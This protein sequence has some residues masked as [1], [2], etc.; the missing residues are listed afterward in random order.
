ML[1]SSRIAESYADHL[2]DYEICYDRRVYFI[3][4]IHF[5]F[6]G[7]FIAEAI[8]IQVKQ[9]FVIF[10]SLEDPSCVGEFLAGL[11]DK[12]PELLFAQLFVADVFDLLDRQ[13]L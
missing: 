7:D 6:E 3:A 4:S 12:S 1:H 2:F 5:T 10:A 9:H 13:I 11:S 8:V